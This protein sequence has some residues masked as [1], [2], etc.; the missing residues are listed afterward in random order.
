MIDKIKDISKKAEELKTEVKKTKIEKKIEEVKEK[1]IEEVINKKEVKLSDKINFLFSKIEFLELNQEEKAEVALK[2]KNDAKADRLY[3]IEIFL[4]WIIASFGL[5][6]NSVAVIIWAMLI[7]P[8]LRPINWIAFWI[9]RWEKKFFFNSIKVLIISSFVSILMWFIVMNLTWLYKETPEILARTSPNIIDLFI[10]IFSAMVALLSLRYKRLWESVAWVAMAAA[11]MPPLWVI[12]M[13]LALWNYNLAWWAGMLFITNI[14]AIIL[15]WVLAFWLYW[16]TPND[17]LK[18]KKS[19]LRIFGIIFL[20]WIISF[21][22]VQNL[23]YLKDRSLIEKKLK[24]NLYLIL[25][26][27]I[28]HFSVSNIKIKE[29]TKNNVKVKIELKI[30]EWVKFYDYYKDFLNETLTKTLWRKTQVEIELIR[31]VNILSKDEEEKRKNELIKIRKNK[32]LEELK[33]QED[34]VEKARKEL[35]EELNSKLKEELEK[36]MKKEFNFLLEKKFLKQ[37]KLNKKLEK[38]KTWSLKNK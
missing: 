1:W 9:A 10:A 27:K 20:I 28:D 6:Q 21:P 24:N 32:N 7:A 14:I 3:W 2:V 38:T 12:W 22:L 25:D 15:V 16:F 5:L 8:F 17:W 11:L 13:E 29:L 23:L 36:K 19:F 33:K 26:K 18:Q 37:E 34:L 30:L 4:S 35:E 31:A